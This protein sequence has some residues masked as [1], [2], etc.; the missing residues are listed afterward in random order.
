MN[1]Y[2]V[3]T[4]SLKGWKVYGKRFVDSFLQYWPIPLVV[5]AEGQLAPEG[6]R[7][8]RELI[9]L[10]LKDDRDHEAFVAKFTHK[11]FNHPTDVNMMSIRFCHKVFAITSPELP[12]AG[13]RIWIDADSETKKPVKPQ[14][15]EKLLPTDKA[16]TF[17]GRKGRMRPGQKAYTECGFVGY[18]QSN[19]L[20]LQQLVDMRE[21]YTSGLL[22]T[23]GQHNW[24][25]SYVFDYTR[26]KLI[27]KELWNNLSEHYQEGDLHVWPK[28]ILGEFMVHNKGPKRKR[29]AYGQQ[30]H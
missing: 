18:N 24:H 12:G 4:F 14:H 19:P 13:W 1:N 6:Y 7:G 20:V 21:I 8:L 25:D 17:L 2:A 5:F 22:F 30:T 3:T 11:R 26:K 27:P 29:K 28:T 16:L 23:L 10:D 9:W 15:I